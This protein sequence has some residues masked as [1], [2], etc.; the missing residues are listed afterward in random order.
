MSDYEF[1]LKHG[2]FVSLT[3]TGP[4][5]NLTH[6][7][8]SLQDGFPEAVMSS[9]DVWNL[10]QSAARVF[11]AQDEDCYSLKEASNG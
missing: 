7:A 10:F 1:V 4:R 9:N 8:G 3:K 6:Y 11:K 2:R 5:W